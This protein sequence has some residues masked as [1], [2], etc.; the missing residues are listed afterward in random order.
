MPADGCGLTPFAVR[1]AVSHGKHCSPG[2]F[3]P[4]GDVMGQDVFPVVRFNHACGHAQRPVEEILTTPWPLQLVSV[5]GGVPQLATHTF[6]QKYQLLDHE[7]VHLVFHLRSVSPVNRGSLPTIF[8]AIW[9]YL[10]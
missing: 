1:V 2:K 8:L 3:W 10:G 6:Y 5:R 9:H 4:E 7:K